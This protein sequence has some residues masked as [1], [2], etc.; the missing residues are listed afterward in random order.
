MQQLQIFEKSGVDLVNMVESGK[1]EIIMIST[2]SSTKQSILSTKYCTKY[3]QV[4]SN[5]C[6]VL[7]T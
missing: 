6:Q 3:Y 7:S 4:S 2:K 1:E 5:K